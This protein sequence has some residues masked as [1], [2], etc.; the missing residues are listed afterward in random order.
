MPK[1]TDI[2][3]VKLSVYDAFIWSSELIDGKTYVKKHLISEAKTQNASV[4]HVLSPAGKSLGRFHM[5][6]N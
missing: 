4:V 6:E 1:I 3:E 5:S 2:L